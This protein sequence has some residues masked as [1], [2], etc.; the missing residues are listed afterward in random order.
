MDAAEILRRGCCFL[1]GVPE[2]K[3]LPDDKGIYRRG[4]ESN[5][6]ITLPGDWSI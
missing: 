1:L 2:E 6:R 3:S 5:E 4:G